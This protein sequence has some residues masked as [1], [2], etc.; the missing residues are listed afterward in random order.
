MDNK[1]RNKEVGK[2]VNQMAETTKIDK[3]NWND[4]DI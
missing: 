1:I 4:T 2:K 3:Y